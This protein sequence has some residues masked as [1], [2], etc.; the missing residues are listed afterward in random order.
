[1]ATFDLY[2]YIRK[3]VNIQRLIRKVG[4]DAENVG[5][6]AEEQPVLYIKAARFY[7]Q[8]LRE[9][10]AAKAKL[11]ETKAAK[12]AELR[13]KLAESGDRVT[14][15]RLQESLSQDKR[16]VECEKELSKA[17]ELETYAKLM[18]EAYKMRRDEITNTI[19]LQQAEVRYQ[20]S[21][22]GGRQIDKL[23]DK[24][25]KKYPE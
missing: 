9:V 24:L 14:E 22:E 16:V 15:G 8:K 25:R 21:L 19:S 11:I 5:K 20:Q 6:A 23:K 18:L 17:E 2:S 13:E 3:P 4:F 10:N 1:M 12:G 7:T